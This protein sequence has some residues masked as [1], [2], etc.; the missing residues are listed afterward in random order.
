VIA[1]AALGVAN[2][3]ELLDHSG[4]VATGR[5]RQSATVAGRCSAPSST[6]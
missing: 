1:L 5:G 6:T 3:P 4:V 2:L